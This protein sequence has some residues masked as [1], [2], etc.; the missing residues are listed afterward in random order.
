MNDKINELLASSHNPE[1][2]SLMVKSA[3]LQVVALIVLLGPF[4]GLTGVGLEGA[5]TGIVENLSQIVGGIL[6]LVSLA[7][8]SYGAIRKLWASRVR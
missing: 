2:L 5:L 6:S 7:G 3:G 1:K 8:V 4:L